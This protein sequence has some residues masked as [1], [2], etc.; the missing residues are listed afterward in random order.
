LVNSRA[1]FAAYDIKRPDSERVQAIPLG[2]SRS[3]WYEVTALGVISESTS[4][5]WSIVDPAEWALRAFAAD[6]DRTA[7]GSALGR[8]C[9]PTKALK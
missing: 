8:E 3:Q 4:A 2:T 5:R 7:A 6:L 9:H 1:T